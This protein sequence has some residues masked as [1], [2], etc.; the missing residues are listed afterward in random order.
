MTTVARGDT[1]ITAMPER[2][3]RSTVRNIPP[4]PAV[5][6]ERRHLVLNFESSGELLPWIGPAIRGIVARRFKERVCSQPPAEQFHRWRY[7]HGCPEQ[8][9]CGYGA[10]YEAGDTNGDETSRPIVIAPMFPLPPRIL[11]GSRLAVTITA[12][13]AT[14]ASHLDELA[15]AICEA[16]KE[17]G[18]G[19]DKIQYKLLPSTV[20]PERHLLMAR[21]FQSPGEVAERCDI[22]LQLTAPLFL[23]VRCG[24]RRSLIDRPPGF[25]RLLAAS[26][27]TVRRLCQQT[28]PDL[29]TLPEAVLQAA[30]GAR[31]HNAKAQRFLQSRS[32]N[33]SN[34]SWQLRGIIG[35]FTYTEVPRAVIPWL[36]V[37]GRLHVGGHRVAGAGGWHVTATTASRPWLSSGGQS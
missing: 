10:T 33:R 35:E 30:R 9:I 24:N 1:T 20:M 16:G 37:A 4:S 27:R 23:R 6:I 18:L 5:L 25:D 31:L 12:I 19:P 13:G 22:R 7:C 28:I 34:Q 32:S 29:P 2:V 26:V 15:A 8:S 3:E 14:A 21:D 36:E 17:P 11:P